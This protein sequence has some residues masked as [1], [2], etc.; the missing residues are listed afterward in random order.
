MTTLHDAAKLAVLP[1]ESAKLLAREEGRDHLVDD[2]NAAIEALRSALAQQ[3]DEYQR[4]FSDGMKEA[5]TGECW[6]RVIDEA[7]VGAHLG[8][9]DIADDYGTAKEKLNDLICWS[10]EV[11]RD[12]AT[13]APQALAQQGGASPNRM[14]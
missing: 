5:P 3:G 12:T 14:G 7:M 1:L 10:V 9:A 4:G 8:V 6:S 11:D 13:P 2:I